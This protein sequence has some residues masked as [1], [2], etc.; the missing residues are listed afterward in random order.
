V[1]VFLVQILIGL[2]R[3]NVKLTTQY[4]SLLDLL[5]VWN[6]DKEEVSTMT[7]VF[8][9]PQIDFG[10]EPRSAF[11]DFARLLAEKLG[12]QAH[13]KTDKEKEEK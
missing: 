3:Y 10:R 12:E 1:L 9:A 13:G 7:T 5:R 2:Y 8:A 4:A 11:E 6:G